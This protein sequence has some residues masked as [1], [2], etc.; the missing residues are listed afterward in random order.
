[1]SFM[2]STSQTTSTAVASPALEVISYASA[3]CGLGMVLVARS[4]KGVC[5][6]A[7]GDDT[8][9]L[10][11][12]LARCFPRALC[13][14]DLVAV[15]DDLKKVI[16]FLDRPVVG[17]HLSLDMRGTPFQRRVW[18][19]LRTIPVGE[20]VTYSELARWISPLAS[21]RAVAGAMAANPI[22][23]AVPC[24]RV[25]RRDGDLAGFRWGVERKRALIEGEALG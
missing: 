13:I 15:G 10:V 20:T 19:K 23:L 11:G 14:L 21:P 6:I 3:E 8:D 9:E 12:D 16:A 18:E 17:L 25:V 1:M 24:H 2:I 5:A 22:A 7:L 4:T